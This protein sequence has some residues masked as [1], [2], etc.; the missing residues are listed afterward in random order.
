MARTGYIPHDDSR[1]EQRREERAEQRVTRD[2]PIDY[3]PPDAR[4]GELDPNAP[5]F[6]TV[7]TF[8]EY[9]DDDSRETYTHHELMCL[10]AR[11]KIRVGLIRSGLSAYGL[12]L[13]HRPHERNVRTFS[14]NSH[15][16]YAGNPMSGGGGAESFRGVAP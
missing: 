5:E 15:N 16:L 4:F 13:A 8:A 1:D 9:L 2:E 3:V 12:T 10:N 11:L 7:D 14:T 6:E